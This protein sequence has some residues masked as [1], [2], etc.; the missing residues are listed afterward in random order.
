MKNLKIS[1]I[2]P[3]YNVA[4]YLGRCMDSLLNQ[5]LQDIE[6]IL[7]DDKSPDDCPKL[8]DEFV[9][10]DK[11]VKVIHKPLNEGLGMARNTGMSIAQGKYI[12]FID[13]D[14]Y[15]SLDMMELLYAKAE[16]KSC[17]AVY[18]GYSYV[19]SDNIEKEYSEFSNET[20]FISNKEC[21]NVF[22]RML[23]G[24]KKVGTV[25]N[26]SV[27][28]SIFALDFLRKNNIKFCSEREYISEDL[29]FDVDL[30]S[31]ITNVTYLPNRGYYYCQNKSSLSQVFRED[32]YQKE[33]VLYSELA[34]RMRT[35]GF[36]NE[37]MY[38]LYY[39]LFRITRFLMR[40]MSIQNIDNSIKK[41]LFNQILNDEDIK[42][43]F[44]NKIPS[45][46]FSFWD[47]ISFLEMKYKLKRLIEM[48]DKL[49]ILA[50]DVKHKFL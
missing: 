19:T 26:M 4:N 9:S 25:L 15:I 2:V 49:W 35:Y 10:L 24:D 48:R 14:D 41:R 36:S 50:R 47:I 18:C 6:I 43:I 13:S 7:V 33:V 23:G 21:R 42:Q 5:T 22:L 29:I 45:K 31:V 17:N 12:A 34:R 37:D 8:C 3:I 46:Y 20:D 28:H 30:F 32:R 16:E 38:S 44:F 27:W 1:I 39:S 11:R 40:D